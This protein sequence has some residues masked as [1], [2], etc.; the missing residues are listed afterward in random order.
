MK[1]THVFGIHEAIAAFNNDDILEYRLLKKLEITPGTNCIQTMK[2]VDEIR[3][4]EAKKAIGKLKIEFPKEK[5][6]SKWKL[7][8][9]YEEQEDPGKQEKETMH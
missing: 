6:P 4:K 3:Y 8:V 7:K 9:E 1:T 5:K 2:N